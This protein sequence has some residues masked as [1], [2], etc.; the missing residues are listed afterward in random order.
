M[1]AR[2]AADVN[3]E[4]K[5]GKEMVGRLASSEHRVHVG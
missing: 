1:D 3:D 5:L 2:Q 4:E